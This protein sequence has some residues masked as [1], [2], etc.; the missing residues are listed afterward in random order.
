M[1]TGDAPRRPDPWRKETER[2]GW[3]GWIAFAGIMLIVLGIFHAM[4]GLLAL[5]E[6]DYYAVGDSG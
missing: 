6:E 2:T 4:M 1:S 3:Y 5:F